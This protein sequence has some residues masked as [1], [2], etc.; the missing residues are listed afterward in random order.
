MAERQAQ[1]VLRRHHVEWWIVAAWASLAL[2]VV[3]GLTAAT[4][5]VS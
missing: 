1:R 3:A 2:V 5:L 4:G